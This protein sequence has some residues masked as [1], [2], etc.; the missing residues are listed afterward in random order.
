MKNETKIRIA[1]WRHDWTDALFDRT[2]ED[3][4]L[5]FVEADYMRVEQ[6]LIESRC[7]W[8]ICSLRD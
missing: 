8:K 5:E 7:H 3:P 4:S 1:R 6:G 2:I